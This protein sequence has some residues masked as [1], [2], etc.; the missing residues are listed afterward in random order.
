M[1]Q[2]LNL[3]KNQHDMKILFIKAAT[4]KNTRSQ[5][6]HWILSK[7]EEENTAIIFKLS[8]KTDEERILNFYEVYINL[9][10]K[11][12]GIIKINSSNT[13]HIHWCKNY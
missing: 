13:P 1:Q 3:F 10:P 9:I 8:E 6:F 4:W 2:A 12:T 7:F 11:L 5:W